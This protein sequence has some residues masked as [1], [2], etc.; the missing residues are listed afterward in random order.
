MTRYFASVILEV[1]IQKALDYLIPEEMIPFIQRGVCVEVP[2]RGRLT[3]GFVL[4]VKTTSEVTK[5]YPISRV[6]SSGAILTED[7]FELALW[8]AKYYV[9]PLGKT[10][11]TILP[12]GVRKHTQL[13]EQY[14][15]CRKVTREE[16]RSVCE[17]MRSKNKAPQQ[18]A[19]LDVMLQVKKGIL[20]R[21]AAQ[22]QQEV[23]SKW[24]DGAVK[25]AKTQRNDV[26]IDKIKIR[27]EGAQEKANGCTNR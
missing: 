18:L 7:L 1:S 22:Q 5:T 13:K 26:L 23:F 19:I 25:S 24:M 2:L 15:V 12:A 11:K 9:A 6:I 21:L 27:T 17:E 14:Y 8:M 4:S 20:H 16:I 3:R 10:I